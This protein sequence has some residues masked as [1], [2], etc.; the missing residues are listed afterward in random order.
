VRPAEVFDVSPEGSVIRFVATI[1]PVFHSSRGVLVVRQE[2][3]GGGVVT[4]LGGGAE[5]HEKL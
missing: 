2:V 3:S 5:K 1:G 4:S